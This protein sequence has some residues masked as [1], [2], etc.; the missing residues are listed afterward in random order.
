MRHAQMEARLR[1]NLS[2]LRGER[3]ETLGIAASLRRKVT[4]LDGDLQTT[5]Q[6]LARVE[7]E[8][9]MMEHDSCAAISLAKSVGSETSSDVDE[10]YKRKVRWLVSLSSFVC[11]VILIARFSVIHVQP[12]VG[13]SEPTLGTARSRGGA[14]ESD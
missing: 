10:F 2:S 4:L 9:I 11:H 3:D 8:K 7:Q 14:K 6:K 13:T 1:S 5:K 12:G